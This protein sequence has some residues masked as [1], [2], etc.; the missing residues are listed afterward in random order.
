MKYI[1]IK[2]T[3]LELSNIIMGC[4]RLNELNLKEAECHISAAIEAGINIF[5]HADIY[6]GGECGKL[7]SR[8]A[9]GIGIS[10]EQII[11]QSKCSIREGYYD[12]SREYI[13]NA[14]DGILSRLNTDYLDILLLHRP[15]ALAN[16]EETAEALEELKRSGKVRYFG[17]SNQ[18][19]GQIELL[20]KYFGEKLL[21][22]QLQFGLAHTLM[23]DEGM[24]VNTG[25]PQAESRTGGVLEYCRLKDITIQA[26][27][28]FQ[29]GL[30]EGTFLGN[31]QYA[32]LNEKINDIAKN[33]GVTPSAIATAWITRHPA[34]IQ[35]ILGT[36]KAKRLKEGCQGA[37]I[38]LTRKE[39]YDL[40]RAAGNR[41]L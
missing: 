16:P 19:P 26:W 3:S 23:L 6:G 4:M 36:T 5:D 40:Y 17:V 9:A 10:R 27:S 41:I 34:D 11:L 30:F 13:L 18:N 35:V 7:F 31:Q 28:P 32:K 12:F 39:W 21:F 25:I 8:A 22:D 15:D 38:P 24:A 2:G 20:Q 14:V 33:Y 37:D 29:K 1:K